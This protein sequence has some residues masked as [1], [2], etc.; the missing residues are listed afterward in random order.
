MAMDFVNAGKPNEAL[1]KMLGNEEKENVAGVDFKKIGLPKAEKPTQ[2]SIT[3]D[4]DIREW[5]KVVSKK[6]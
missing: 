4:Q 1:N 3:F 5:L 2:T 6:Q